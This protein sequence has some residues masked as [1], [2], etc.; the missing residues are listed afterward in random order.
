MMNA[1]E[2][3]FEW[4]I[5][6]ANASETL[7]KNILQVIKD[8]RSGHLSIN[9]A[10]VLRHHARDASIQLLKREQKH[11]VGEYR[12]FLTI[13][14]GKSEIGEVVAFF[15]PNDALLENLLKEH[16]NNNSNLD[17]IHERNT[18]VS[19]SK[20][21]L[22][23]LQK[24]VLERMKELLAITPVR[25]GFWEGLVIPEN[26]PADIHDIKKACVKILT[27][28]KQEMI[29]EQG[30]DELYISGSFE[31]AVMDDPEMQKIINFFN[32][33]RDPFDAWILWKIPVSNREWADWTAAKPLTEDELKRIQETEALIYAEIEEYKKW[34]Q[35][36]NGEEIDYGALEAEMRTDPEWVKKF[37]ILGYDS[38][39]F[40][41]F[42][43]GKPMKWAQAMRDPQMLIPPDN[44]IA[45]ED[46]HFTAVPLD[47]V[48]FTQER[49][50][51]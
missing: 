26:M 42:V 27:R 28:K 48:G 15:A 30:W 38:D 37:D 25:E 23:N 32:V 11:F 34:Y 35:E 12:D 14:R 33:F 6:V 29:E 47:Q 45:I 49:L 40:S 24:T 21:I 22:E 16:P 2:Q 41:F 46:V 20:I 51:I 5:G 31:R 17:P 10:E 39:V 18:L 13:L 7:R 44:E 36:R 19:E 3:I 9:E 43:L 50:S 1:S 8:L 4:Q